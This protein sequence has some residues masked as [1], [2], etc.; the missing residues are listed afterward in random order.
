MYKDDTIMMVEVRN[1]VKMLA[2][3]NKKMT[4]RFVML[5][6]FIEKLDGA[7]VQENLLKTAKDQVCMLNLGIKKCIILVCVLNMH[8][9]YL[10]FAC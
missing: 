9:D 7:A 4:E 1:W 6:N 8:A 10:C 5:K 2:S 3:I